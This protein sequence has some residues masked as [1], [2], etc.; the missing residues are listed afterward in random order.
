MPVATVDVGWR[1]PCGGGG[2]FRLLPY[3]VSR[4]LLDH[5]IRG[6][7][8]PAT[9]YFHPWE[10]DAGQPGSK[11]CRRAL[12]SG[13]TSI[14]RGWRHKLARLIR[15]FAWGPDRRDCLPTTDGPLPRWAPAGSV[16]GHSAP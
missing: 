14:L 4:R 5:L 12:A 10:I 15:E 13:T 9:F 1:M 11:V 16:A 3:A 6:E 2:Y 8:V 7:R